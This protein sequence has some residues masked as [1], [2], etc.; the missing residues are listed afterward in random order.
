MRLDL[1]NLGG[2]TTVNGETPVTAL[3]M[4]TTPAQ[5]G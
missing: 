3:T 5:G 1:G 4:A 2:G